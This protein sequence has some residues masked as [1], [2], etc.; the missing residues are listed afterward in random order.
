[1]HPTL[2]ARALDLVLVVGEVAP[3]A[4]AH[5]A[6]LPPAVVG[7]GLPNAR[8]R[9][10][11]LIWVG[12]HTCRAR[13]RGPAMALYGL[14]AQVVS[15]LVAP[16]LLRRTISSANRSALSLIR[17]A[18]EEGSGASGSAEAVPVCYHLRTESTLAWWAAFLGDAEAIHAPGSG[19]APVPAGEPRYVFHDMHS[20]HYWGRYN[21]TR[22][23]IVYPAGAFKTS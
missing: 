6:P 1:M 9:C 16:V 18:A 12:Q 4:L 14:A 19:R 11:C 10:T 23:T 7:S 5:P 3:A 21:A 13:A 20:R 2:K 8:W 22:G 17:G 15:V